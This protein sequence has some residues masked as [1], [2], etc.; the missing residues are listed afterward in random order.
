MSTYNL[1]VRTLPFAGDAIFSGTVVALTA[2]GLVEAIDGTDHLQGDATPL[3]V[4]TEDSDT[5]EAPVW[6][7][8]C[9]G[10][11]QVRA[12]DDITTGDLLVLGDGDTAGH[13]VP[14]DGDNG[15]PIALALGDAEEDALCEVMFLSGAQLMSVV[16]EPPAAPAELIATDDNFVCETGT[17]AGE[18]VGNVL[19][20]DT[21][22]G[23]LA[24]TGDVTITIVTAAAGETTPTLN[25]TTG[26]VSVPEG[27]PDDTYTIVY[28]LT[29]K[30]DDTNTDTATVTITVGAQGET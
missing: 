15:L 21:Y 4:V 25:T 24:T 10:T 19:T 26:D 17:T 18:T 23:A 9:A 7:L 2:A 16:Y 12:G 29:D 27:T 13:L 22:D 5:G 8:N 14:L 20:N 30:E 28:K 3:G 1:G 11:I 6:L